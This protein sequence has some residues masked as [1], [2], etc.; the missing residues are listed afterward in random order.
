MKK[1][2]HISDKTAE[3]QR[4]IDSAEA[5][6]TP[7]EDV[8]V[9]GEEVDG[10]TDLV[11]EGPDL[12]KKRVKAIQKVFNDYE[13]AKRELSGGNLRLVVSIAKK[14]RNRG[15][16]F[17][18]IMSCG[19]GAV[20][21]VFLIMNH[22]IEKE[23]VELNENLLAEVSMLEEDVVDGELGLVRLRNTL[24]ETDLQI[25]DAQG[26]ATRISEEIEEYE[27]QIAA[28]KA[29]GYTD[30]SEI[31]AQKAELLSLE[32]GANVE[33][34]SNIA[35]LSSQLQNSLAEQESLIN[36]LRDLTEDR[37]SLADALAVAQ[38]E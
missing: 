13:Q 31:E 10:L 26:L 23:S 4:A 34:Q 21:L 22:A 3:V 15:L 29:E 19:F 9:M 8:E 5:N 7:P 36:Q 35:E 11:M 38:V 24:S 18:D 6:R 27:A 14:Y 17:L 1:L 20:I 12:L 37:D 16:S 30:S 28:R 2:V 32:R 33:L 25:V